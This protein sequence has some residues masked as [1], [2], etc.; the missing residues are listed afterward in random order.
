[1]KYV[2]EEGRIYVMKDWVRDMRAMDMGDEI[3]DGIGDGMGDGVGYGM[4]DGVGDGMGDGVGNRM[5]TGWETG[6]ET[7]GISIQATPP[8]YLP[9][10]WWS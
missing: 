4:G 9:W 3:R 7:G 6:W 5:G 2:M 10:L 1:M 8:S